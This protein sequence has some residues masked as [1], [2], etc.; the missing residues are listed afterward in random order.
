MAKSVTRRATVRQPTA[1]AEALAQVAQ[2]DG[3]SLAEAA[4]C[5]VARYITARH[6]DPEFQARLRERIQADQNVLRGAGGQ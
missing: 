1:Q 3:M 5:A 2:V 4:R 6:A